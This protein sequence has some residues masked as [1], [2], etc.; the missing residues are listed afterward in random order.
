MIE[1][2]TIKRGSLCIG[3]WGVETSN[4]DT[5]FRRTLIVDHEKMDTFTMRFLDVLLE[6]Q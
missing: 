4:L 6:G 1:D 3:T 2:V 5:W